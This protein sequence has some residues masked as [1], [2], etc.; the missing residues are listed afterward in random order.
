[1][2]TLCE[3]GCGQLAPI[4]THT[5]LR[6][7]IRKGE[8]RRFIS[9]HQFSVPGNRKRVKTLEELF[10]PRV[11][12]TDKCWEWTGGLDRQG[13]GKFYNQRGAPRAHRFSYELAFGPIPQGKL[14][15]HHCDNPKCIRP[16]HLFIG[17][18]KDNTQDAVRK[19]RLSRTHQWRSAIGRRKSQIL[20]T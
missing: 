17:T 11:L 15:C 3:C 1:M 7:G 2:S 18:H 14:V 9:G 12:K 10:W 20:L 8:S 4:C 6:E 16:D 19:N 13:Y 5:N